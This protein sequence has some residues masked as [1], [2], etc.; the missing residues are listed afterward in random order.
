MK[1]RCLTEVSGLVSHYL[2]KEFNSIFK[3]SEISFNLVFQIE[4][5]KK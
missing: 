4:R 5:L 1:L 2:G 3:G